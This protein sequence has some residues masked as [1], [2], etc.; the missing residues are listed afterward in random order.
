MPICHTLRW[1]YKIV[2]TKN[3]IRWKDVESR[4]KSSE[5][6]AFSCSVGDTTKER[7]TKQ[8]TGKWMRMGLARPKKHADIKYSLAKRVDLWIK[9]TVAVSTPVLSSTLKR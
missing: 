5:R 8:V 2:K 4:H 6:E 7:L 3:R 1:K 9:F